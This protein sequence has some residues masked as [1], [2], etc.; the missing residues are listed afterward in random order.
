MHLLLHVPDPEEVLILKFVASL[1]MQFH[2]EVDL[3]ENPTLYK[4]FQRSLA[5]ERKLTPRGC[6]P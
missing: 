1:L 2:R 6:I 3:F 5:I 4:T